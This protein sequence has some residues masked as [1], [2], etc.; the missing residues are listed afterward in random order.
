MDMNINTQHDFF[1][2]EHVKQLLT[3]SYKAGYIFLQFN[4]IRFCDD[5]VTDGLYNADDRCFVLY[6]YVQRACQFIDDV[7][8]DRFDLH[9]LDDSQFDLLCKH[10]IEKNLYVS[11]L[12]KIKAYYNDA[13]VSKS[14]YVLPNYFTLAPRPS[15]YF[16]E[17]TP[18][19]AYAKLTDVIEIAKTYALL[20]K[21]GA[22]Q[23]FKSKI[24]Q[25]ADEREKIKELCK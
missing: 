15:Y 7:I 19:E 22:G 5:D 20:K 13:M 4:D 3:E 10:F 21:T 12:G 2:S 25:A 1:E 9:T 8:H 24:V 14:I 6:L 11:L 17:M 23:V 16:D 18:D